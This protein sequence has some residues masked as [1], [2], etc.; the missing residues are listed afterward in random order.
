LNIII[1]IGT[2]KTGTSSIQEFLHRNRKQLNKNGYY[3]LRSP[4]LRNHRKLA[5]L[6]MSSE[7]KDLF[8]IQNKIEEHN[9][10]A[11]WKQKTVNAIYSELSSIPNTIHTVVVSSEHFH[12]RLTNELELKELKSLFEDVFDPC[13]FQIVCYLRRQDKLAVSLHSTRLKINYDSKR[14]F[15]DV[16]E[17]NHY[18]NYE[19][20]LS[21][22]AKT[23]GQKCLNVRLFEKNLFI[24]RDLLEDFLST[25]NIG[26]DERYIRTKEQNIS[27]TSKQRFLMIEINRDKMIPFK[28]RQSIKRYILED[29]SDRY[30]DRGFSVSAKSAKEFYFL[31]KESNNSVA[32]TFFNRQSLFDESFNDEGNDADL[33][34]PS[35]NIEVESLKKEFKDKLFPF[36]RLHLAGVRY[37]LFLSLPLSFQILLRKYL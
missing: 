11:L 22:W 8:T 21:L 29:I 20:M 3:Y 18:Y 16:T 28:F 10:R 1:H 5:H 25:V 15:P 27:L 26:F 31:F 7:K 12:S 33:P 6:V 23:F 19:K 2:E 4:G 34:D 14:I 35:I 32:K 9:A 36:P 30:K 37:Y 13:N 24:N 17:N